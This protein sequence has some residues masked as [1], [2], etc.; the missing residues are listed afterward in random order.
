MKL[1]TVR[2]IMMKKM[3][4]KACKI[5][6]KPPIIVGSFVGG[7]WEM[8]FG[9]YDVVM[10]GDTEC[11]IVT[12]VITLDRGPANADTTVIIMT[13]TNMSLATFN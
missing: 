8:F 9:V 12:P 6:V 1:T 3:M 2:T 10:L 11:E 5:G 4:G 13:R 7:A